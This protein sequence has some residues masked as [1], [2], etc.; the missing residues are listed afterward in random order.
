MPGSWPQD[1][2]PSLNSDNHSIT[3]KA[4]RQ[5]NC[6]AWAARETSRRWEPDRLGIYYWPSGVPRTLTVDAF[7]RAYGTLGFRLCFDGSL[8]PEIEKI[9]IFVIERG[10]SKIPTHAA[11]QLASGEWTSKLGDCEDIS[12]ATVEAVSGPIYGKPFCYLSR[13]RLA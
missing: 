10:D 13:P 3:S 7:V 5:Y 2:F 12:H 8:E 9:A 4:T 6:L 11:L 1:N